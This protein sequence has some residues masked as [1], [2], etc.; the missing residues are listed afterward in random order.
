MKIQN[1]I[2]LTHIHKHKTLHYSVYI[3]IMSNIIN[4]CL[5]VLQKGIYSLRMFLYIAQGCYSYSKKIIS[6]RYN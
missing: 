1:D 2:S 3:Y 4:F 6:N 5:L